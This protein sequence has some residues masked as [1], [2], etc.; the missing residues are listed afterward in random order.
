MNHYFYSQSQNRHIAVR[1]NG[2]AYNMTPDYERVP[3]TQKLRDMAK[4][5]SIATY[6]PKIQHDKMTG[7]KKLFFAKL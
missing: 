3:S 4:R 1:L 6:L 7:Y 2:V 5:G